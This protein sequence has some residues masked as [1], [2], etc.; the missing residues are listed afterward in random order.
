MT[1]FAHFTGPARGGVRAQDDEHLQARHLLLP[2]LL[3][4]AAMA[5]VLVIATGTRGEPPR[6][7]TNSP[8][9]AEPSDLISHGAWGA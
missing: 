6:S 1:L 7:A 9:P 3:W 5:A 2:A 8:V 4:G